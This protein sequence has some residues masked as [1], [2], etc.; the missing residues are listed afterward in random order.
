[1]KYPA[2]NSFINTLN[3]VKIVKNMLT[4]LP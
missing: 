2:L 3:E 4:N 1:M